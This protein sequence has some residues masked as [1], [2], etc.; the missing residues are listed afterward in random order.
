[1]L[2]N[3]NYIYDNIIIADEKTT[4]KQYCKKAQV[5]VDLSVKCISEFITPGKVLNSKTYAAKTT[6]INKQ[7]FFTEDTGEK[8]GWFLAPGTYNLTLNEGCKFG[9]NDTGLIIMR[10]SLNRCGVSIFSAVWD[11]G[12]TTQENE[13]INEMNIRISVD[14]KDGFYLEENSRVAQLL[15]FENEDTNLY[16]GQWQSGRTTSK[17]TEEK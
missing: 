6:L 14:N 11:P 9:P 10:S 17:L 13:K 7:T 15:V 8:T 3:A 1:M 2:K 12:F 5:G 4:T 16:D